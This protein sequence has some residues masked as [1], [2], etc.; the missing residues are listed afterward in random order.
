MRTPKVTEVALRLE[1]VTP[2]VFIACAKETR[3]GPARPCP[4]GGRAQ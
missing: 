3:I 4:Q 1:P 2:D